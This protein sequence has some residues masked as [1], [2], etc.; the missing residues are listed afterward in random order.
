[1]A[2][3]M[4]KTAARKLTHSQGCRSHRIIGG[5]IKEDGVWGPQLGQ[6]AE[7]W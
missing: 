5:D 2:K 7:L 4:W 1:M 3:R 6:G